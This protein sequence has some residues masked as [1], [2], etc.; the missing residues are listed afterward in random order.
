MEDDRS[1]IAT[2]AECGATVGWH[3]PGKHAAKDVAR[4]ISLGLNIERCT[5]D[6]AKV[7]RWGHDKSCSHY[8]EPK[9]KQKTLL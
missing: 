6:E 2:C 1:Y 5:T 9:P 7:R 4:W 3:A 8:H